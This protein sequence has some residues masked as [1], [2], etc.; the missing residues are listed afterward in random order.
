MHKCCCWPT[1]E[2]RGLRST[3]QQSPR[4]QERGRR[5]RYRFLLLTRMV[6]PIGTNAVSIPKPPELLSLAQI[7]RDSEHLTA[8]TV[9]YPD[10]PLGFE[11]ADLFERI[12]PDIRLRNLTRWLAENGG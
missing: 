7:R 4:R 6:P 5:R 2:N 1:K 12:A 11:E 9:I 10:P 8:P 3:M